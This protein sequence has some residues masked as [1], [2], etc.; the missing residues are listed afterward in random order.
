MII[1]FL[2]MRRSGL[3][4]I[5]NSI[6]Y[7]LVGKTEFERVFDLE[8]YMDN[9]EKCLTSRE[10][11][12]FND[13]KPETNFKD[14][15][16]LR[17]E[18]IKLFL[19][20][21]PPVNLYSKIDFGE[22]NVIIIRDLLNNIASRLERKKNF[23]RVND[24]YFERLKKLL[25]EALLIENELQNK[26]V[27]KYDDFIKNEE[28]RTKILGRMGIDQTVPYSKFQNE[29]PKY[30]K[31]SSFKLGLETVDKRFYF[32]KFPKN[33]ILVLK[34]DMELKELVEQLYGPGYDL[35]R[36]I[37]LLNRR[38]NK[39]IFFYYKIFKG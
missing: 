32:V 10:I 26:I 29:I 8:K 27:V 13:V 23:S 1:N 12:F 24:L 14:L 17:Q 22:Y 36:K 15:L 18:K 21:D 39:L 5:L 3:H 25:R 30:G 4:I 16:S 11:I 20:E 9:Y 7:N 34:E 35:N 2:G 28:Y 31:G 38:R 33:V 37:K 6:K 19:H